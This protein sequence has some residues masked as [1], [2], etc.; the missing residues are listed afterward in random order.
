M[1]RDYHIPKNFEHFLY[2]SGVLQA[3]GMKIGIEAQ[4][5]AKPFC[6]G[7]L[8]WQL[9]DCWPVVSWSGIDGYGNWKALHYFVKKAYKDL[10]V[11]PV[12]EEGKLKVY[13]VSDRLK[14]LEGVL[15]LQLMKL[16]GK[17]LWKKRIDASI[18]ANSS[19]NFFEEDVQN[20]LKNYDKRNLVFRASFQQ[21][22]ETLASNLYYFVP[23]KALRL[24]APNIKAAIFHTEKGKAVVEL[25]CE[26]LARNVY[27]R[28]EEVRGF[29]TD[30]YFDLLSGERV[31]VEY[32][33]ERQ[34]EDL[35]SKLK[36]I[37]LFDTQK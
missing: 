7:T 35:S 11:S 12:E 37:S 25:S 2:V 28:I 24:T 29:F 21:E 22:A 9:N 18:K 23:P 27:L 14:P 19:E 30:N 26:V 33:T 34:E 13:V 32:R 10:L 5:R 20:L 16:S 6:M 31:R 4:R 15:S 1:E 36:I 8:Y 17:V 3:E